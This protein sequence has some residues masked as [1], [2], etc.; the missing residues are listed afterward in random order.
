[1]IRRFWGHWQQHRLIPW[2]STQPPPSDPSQLGEAA[3]RLLD[4]PTLQLALERVQAKLIESW[5]NTAVGA[6]E[7][8]EAA[9]RLWWASEQLKTELRI[10]L[11]NARAIE[12]R[13]RAA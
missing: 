11:G 3:R 5:R 12:A 1:M 2:R 8:R 7:E 10:M 13:Q 4:D 9:Y 6:L